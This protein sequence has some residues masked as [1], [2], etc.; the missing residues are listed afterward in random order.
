MRTESFLIERILAHTQIWSPL[1]T[2]R[3]IYRGHAG[4][5]NGV[6]AV[7]WSP[8]GAFLASGDNQGAVHLWEAEHGAC[9]LIYRA[10]EGGISTL[11][12][13]SDGTRSLSVDDEGEVQ[14]WRAR[15][16]ATL[17]MARASSP[18]AG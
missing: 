9:S 15:P 18:Q 17:A 7:D 4:R 16:E 10:H 14:I 8:D 2:T 3:L 5:L 1:G 6:Y 12:G 13:L 11:A